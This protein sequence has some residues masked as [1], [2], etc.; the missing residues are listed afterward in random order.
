MNNKI[1]AAGLAVGLLAGAGIGYALENSGNADAE[2][3]SE[4]VVAPGDNGTTPINLGDGGQGNQDGFD[5][6]VRMQAALQP[7]ID[8]G[9]ITQAQADKVIAALVAADPLGRRRGGDGDGDHGGLGGDD[10]QNGLPGKPG[11]PGT[12]GTVPF[13]DGGPAD[14]T[15]TT[16]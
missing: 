11:Q 4:V 10:D 16:G 9:T 5:P 2:H 15:T 6:Y 8:N 3:R 12:I 7:L 14:T 13:I 1:V